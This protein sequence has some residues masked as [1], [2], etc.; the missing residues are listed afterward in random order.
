MGESV[1][2]QIK[3]LQGVQTQARSV[4]LILEVEAR[5][6]TAI[7]QGASTL[8]HEILDDAVKNQAIIEGA[9]DLLAGLLSVNALR[10]SARSMK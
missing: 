6:S 8:Y 2:L 5:P 10:P 9:G 1:V 7:A 4:D 3:R